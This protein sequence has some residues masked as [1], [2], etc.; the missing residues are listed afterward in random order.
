MT[1][2]SVN[3]NLKSAKKKQALSRREFGQLVGLAAPGA[4]LLAATSKLSSADVVQ[5]P[6]AAAIAQV[7][8]PPHRPIFIDGIHAYADKLSVK[9]GENIN[10]YVSSDSP[11]SMQIFRLGTDPDTPNSDQ[12]MSNTFAPTP[13]QQKI[14]PGSYVYV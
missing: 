2:K 5:G 11:Y 4:A 8:L 14:Y 12:P 1:R 7:P 10:F 9:P 3:T 6:D 13:S